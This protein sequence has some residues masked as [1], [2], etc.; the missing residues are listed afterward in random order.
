MN[1]CIVASQFNPNYV[2]S[3]VNA[4]TNELRSIMPG[5]FVHLVQ[6]PG[7][8]EIPL[9]VKKTIQDKTPNAVI[10]IGVVIEGETDH[11]RLIS[12]A[13]TFWLQQISLDTSVPIIHCVLSV[14]NEQQAEARCAEQ[15]EINRGVEAARAAV[16]MARLFEPNSARS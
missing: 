1:F 7:A 15:S 12:E 8:F 14:K 6:V 2:Q 9:A 5:S 4:A 13:T 11:A 16:A 3:L 10:A